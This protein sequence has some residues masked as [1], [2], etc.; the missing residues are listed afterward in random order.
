MTIT[1][2]IG[3]VDTGCRFPSSA[4]GDLISPSD[5]LSKAGR[6]STLVP[7]PSL[8]GSS[9]GFGEEKTPAVSLARRGGGLKQGL[10]LFIHISLP[11]RNNC[12]VLNTAL[13]VLELS[14]SIEVYEMRFIC[15]NP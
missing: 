1:L 3:P 9:L 13:Y 11:L 6:S 4:A 7:S 10:S 14:T 8:A 15:N 5:F 2:L 12:P